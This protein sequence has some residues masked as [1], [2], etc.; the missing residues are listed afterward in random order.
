[1]VTDVAWSGSITGR[2]SVQLSADRLLASRSVNGAGVAS[3][4]DSV[5]F[6]TWPT[7]SSRSRRMAPW[8]CGVRTLP[9]QGG[10]GA[11]TPASSAGVA[12]APR[13]SV[14]KDLVSIWR[15]GALSQNE[16]ICLRISAGWTMTVSWSSRGN[17]QS[18][19]G[20]P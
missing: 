19:L 5:V 15:R 9:V 16:T 2:V 8:L 10:P 7:G 17:S 4:H 3:T 14:F 18:R 20:P 12:T 6:M 1:M 11:L 13:A